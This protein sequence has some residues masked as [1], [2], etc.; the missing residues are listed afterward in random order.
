VLMGVNRIVVTGGKLRATMGFHI[1]TVDRLH[2]EEASALD[3]RTGAS[4]SFGFGPWSASAYVGFSYVRSTKADSDAQINVETDLTG[5]VEIHFKSDYF[6]LERF[7][8]GDRID[9][10]RG[11]TP[12]PEANAPSTADTPPWG[13]SITPYP[14]SAAPL[15]ARPAPSAAPPAAPAPAPPAPAA[16]APARA[17]P[18]PAAPAPTPGSTPPAAP[19]PTPG[20]TPPA[21][22]A[23][24]GSPPPARAGS[25][26]PPTPPAAS[27][28]PPGSASPASPAPPG[29]APPPAGSPPAQPP[30]SP[31]PPTSPASPAPASPPAGAP[32]AGSGSSTV[33]D[34][35]R[36]VADVAT[37]LAPLIDTVRNVAGTPST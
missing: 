12:V 5:E 18:P 26:P 17:A 28:A 8:R 3:F 7:A 9:R 10:I 33:A 37:R 1:D 23:P 19:A 30:G 16:P 11:N 31:T 29:G 15:P 25:P 2:Q 24:A 13:S 14:R 6:P 34:T 36:Q 32:P 20:S 4:G 21:A 27:P 22:P 35:V